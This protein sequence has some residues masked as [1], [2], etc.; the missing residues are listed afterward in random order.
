VLKNFIRIEGIM[1]CFIYAVIL[2]K[3]LLGTIIRTVGPL[4]SSRMGIQAKSK[5]QFN[6]AEGWPDPKGIDVH[7]WWPNSPHGSIIEH[8]WAPPKCMVCDSDQLPKNQEELWLAL[9]ETWEN[10][11]Q[12]FI[13]RLLSPPPPL[14][15]NLE[16]GQTKLSRPIMDQFPRFLAQSRR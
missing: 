7:P 15:T 8:F 16:L 1:D 11:D 10:I 3:Y 9:K 12:E 13:D 6:H 14:R 5:H 4:F 2:S